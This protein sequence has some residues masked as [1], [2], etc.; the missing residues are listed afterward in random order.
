MFGVTGLRT[1]HFHEPPDDTAERECDDYPNDER[2]VPGRDVELAL[3]PPLERK[4]DR[5]RQRSGDQAGTQ[6][7]EQRRLDDDEEDQRPQRLPGLPGEHEHQ[8]GRDRGVGE[9]A[10]EDEVAAAP[11][12]AVREPEQDERDDGRRS[13]QD[14]GRLLVAGWEALA[15]DEDLHAR[16]GD[17]TQAREREDPDQVHTRLRSSIL[18]SAQRACSLKTSSSSSA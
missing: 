11:L 2:V 12:P 1:L 8:A 6:P 3:T 16:E 14:P 15:I 9:H 7:E 17:E 10:G 13:D 18:A 5:Q 4:Q